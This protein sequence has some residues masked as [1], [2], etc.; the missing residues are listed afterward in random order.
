ML[1]EACYLASFQTASWSEINAF[2]ER[3][4]SDA[5]SAEWLTDAAQSFSA[6]LL[7][8]FPSV[9][10]ARVFVVVPFDRLPA[11]D[12]EVAQS[13][14]EKVNAAQLLVPTTPVLSLLGTS[15]VAESWNDRRFS[16]GH[17]AI[18]L[19]SRELVEGAPMLAQ[20]LSDLK[21]D[22]ACLDDARPID[23][24]RMMGGTNQRFYVQSANT[25]L[26]ARGRFIIPAR[27]FVA[28]Y[29]V[30]T[31]FGMAGAYVQGTIVAAI[32]FTTE[33]LESQVIDRYP[34]II[35]NFRMA[36]TTAVLARRLY[37]PARPAR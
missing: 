37:A 31:V 20:L 30:E 17:L 19:L 34:S 25:A 2:R 9:V 12:A 1:S 23:S 27:D 29:Q 5:G 21:L 7:T 33:R 10:L 26:D 14:A 3:V 13:F 8:E 4:A 24:K 32:V 18:P 15:G 6:A 11:V 36:T 35:G 22:L 28:K 16:S